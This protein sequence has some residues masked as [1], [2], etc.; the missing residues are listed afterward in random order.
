MLLVQITDVMSTFALVSQAL[1]TGEPMN[2]VFHQNLLDRL[3]Y[4]GN[5]AYPA[6]TGDDPPKGGH[7][8][9]L[10]I[11]TTY[12][13]MFFAAGISAILQLLEVCLII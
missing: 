12:D 11:L 4:H 7:A 5:V 10:D 8:D 13:Y 9:L 1:R 3:I 6:P 2:Q